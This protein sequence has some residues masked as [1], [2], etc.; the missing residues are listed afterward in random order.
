MSRDF[1]RDFLTRVRRLLDGGTVSDEAFERLARH[2]RE[3]GVLGR[4]SGRPP[5]ARGA[6]GEG[7]LARGRVQLGLLLAPPARGERA[8]RVLSN[9]LRFG[10]R[11]DG[12]TGPRDL[13]SNVRATGREA[14]RVA[15]RRRFAARRLRRRPER[16]VGGRPVGP[17][18]R[19]PGTSPTGFEA[20]RRSRADWR[21]SRPRI[22]GG[23]SGS[24]VFV[25]GAARRAKP[26]TGR[27]RPRPSGSAGGNAAR[28]HRLAGRRLIF[29]AALSMASSLFRTKSLDRILADAE[30]PEHQMKRTLGPIQLIALGIGAIIGAG[31]FATDRVGGGGRRPA[32][33]AR[34]RPW[35]SRSSSRRSAAASARSAT[36][37]SPR[38]SRSRAAPTP[39]PTPR[40]ASSSPGS[41]AGT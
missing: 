28:S 29:S 20:F 26:R 2:F 38:S 6:R 15:A 35:S 36:P 1:W 7:S 9:H 32:T 37:S 12:K 3:P 34:A 16:R 22:A 13:P 40:S 18:R 33:T 31:I 4:L 30:E 41:S 21:L 39:T 24:R 19:A 25:P 14:D 23:H 27:A 10:D 5:D 17:E 11:A 8:H